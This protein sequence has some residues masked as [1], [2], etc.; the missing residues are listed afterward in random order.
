MEPIFIRFSYFLYKSASASV[1][2]EN[3]PFSRQPYQ[4]EKE[5]KYRFNLIT[6]NEGS[7][8]FNA[9]DFQHAQ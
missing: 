8:L 2:K 6:I 5:G 1:V 9:A 3:R 7:V 4:H